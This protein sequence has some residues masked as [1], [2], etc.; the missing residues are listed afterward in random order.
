MSRREWLMLSLMIITIASVIIGGIVDA[1]P[2][3]GPDTGIEFVGVPGRVYPVQFADGTRCLL[4]KA[5]DS[6]ALECLSR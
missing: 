2:E 1:W 5:G 6:L 3:P 4:W